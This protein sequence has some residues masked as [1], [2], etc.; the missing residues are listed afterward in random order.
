METGK[1]NSNNLMKYIDNNIY[2]YIYFFIQSI[3]IYS[4]L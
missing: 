2:I 4:I 3:T 1:L